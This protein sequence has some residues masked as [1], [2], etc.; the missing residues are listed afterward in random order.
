MR[1]KYEASRPKRRYGLLLIP[2][3]ILALAAGALFLIPRGDTPDTPPA[4]PQIS[5]TTLPETSAETTTETTL[6]EP[7]HVVATARLSAMG[8]LLMHGPIFAANTAV[9]Q[10]DGTYD[11][12]SVFRYIS[13]YVKKADYA[14]ANLETTLRG[15]DVAYAGYPNFNCP[16]NIVDSAVAAGFTA[17]QTANN[18]CYDTLMAGLTRTVEVVRQAGIP[19]YGVRLSGDEPRYH[20]ADVNG[21][22]IGFVCYTYTTSMGENGRPRLNGNSPVEKPELVNF[23]SYGNLDGFYTELSGIREQML[24]EG[25]EATVF[26]V[27]WGTEYE[28]T[29]NNYQ[30]QIA[31]KVCDMGFDAIIGAH[32]HVMQPA[33]LLRSTEDPSHLTA[34]IYSLGN[35]VSNQRREL[36]NLNT[37]NTE[38]GALFS[39]SFDK[40]SDGTVYLADAELLP[41]WVN[42]HTGDRGVE[43]NILPLDNDTRED[44]QNLYQLT[45]REYSR[46]LESYDRT[47]A[48]TGAGMADIRQALAQARETR[49]AAYLAAVGR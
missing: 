45:D 15:P 36:M 24:A 10:A 33:A 6:P 13:D 19:A 31:Q 26:L 12:S 22:R 1:G 48:I 16:D 28:L 43:Y 47:D 7:E 37:G 32:P 25:A 44:W 30:Q 34:C 40:Y 8:D 2:V 9:R 49:D 17:L 41:T 18:H 21:I 35:A 4:V 14:V 38:D 5:G 27:H 20:V 39:V 29:E 23:F 42:M 11:F 3:L 46:S